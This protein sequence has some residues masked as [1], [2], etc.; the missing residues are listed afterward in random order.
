V[1]IDSILLNIVG[2]IIAALFGD[3]AG[4]MWR[5][6]PEVTNYFIFR[7]S[8]AGA[9]SFAITLAYYVYL[10]GSPSGQTVGK[11]VMGIRV[12][13]F[14]DGAPIGHGR[15]ALRYI[16]TILSAIPLGLGYFWMLWDD[17]K[18][19]WHDKIATTVVVP[20]SAAPVD[21]WPG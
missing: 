16:G 17:Q 12:V 11:K 9:L 21:K 20:E 14:A 10:H 6:D 4:V 8:L 7:A 15:A 5:S 1:V 18:Q 3:P 19:T 2:T 13:G